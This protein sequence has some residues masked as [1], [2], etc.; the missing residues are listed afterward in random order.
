MYER[1]LKTIGNLGSPKIM[2]VG[3]FALDVYVYGDAVRISPEAPVPVLKVM[4]TE[5]RCGSAACVAAQVAALGATAVCIGA[6][7]RDGHG[8]ILRDRLA[9]LGADT[10]GLYEASD[11]PTATRQRLI[12]LARHRH[13]QQLL[14]IDQKSPE[15]LPAGISD[16]LVRH[17]ERR[18]PEVEIVCL[19]DR[20]GSLL[21]PAICARM[22]DLARRAGRRVLVDPALGR[23][24]SRYRGATALL[25][26][27]EEA[28]AATGLA[29]ESAAGAAA[30]A[31]RLLE[32]F[33]LDAVVVTL[34]KEGAYLAQSET[35]ELV[36]ARPRNVYDV[37]G[38]GDVVLATLAVSLAGNDDYLAAVHLANVAGGI[39]VE[40]FGAVPVTTSEMMHEIAHQ[41]GIRN[42][43]LRSLE[44]LLEELKQA[45]SRGRTVVFTNG[46]FDII[47][48]GH[49]EYLRFCKAQG[50]IVVLGLNSDR[51]VREIKGP[52][53]PINNQQDRAA[54]LS[55]LDSIDFVAIFDE[56][57]PLNLIRQVRPDILVKGA[58]W[59]DKGVVGADF[60]ESCGGRVVLAPLVEGKSSTATIEKMKALQTKR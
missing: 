23:D 51:S 3:D 57:D 2:V 29:I 37:T 49:V 1:L 8:E 38:A 21:T 25:P 7:G 59:K 10:S 36:P 44:A 46:C 26:N 55:G 60:V 41:Y 4:E 28:M 27:R 40:R 48:R 42:T 16:E 12:G 54:V 22:I 32:E 20:E 56:P 58:D 9:A 34:D 39:E 15:P 6:V 53:R 33:A 5:Y 19:Q 18:L 30:A 43:K 35:G 45:R 11:R 13:K 17:F 50:D 52:E 31:R 47:H 24:Y 14:R